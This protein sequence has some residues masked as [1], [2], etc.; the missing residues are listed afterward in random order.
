MFFI[1]RK[2]AVFCIIKEEFNLIDWTMTVL[3]HDQFS[4]V[5]WHKIRFVLVIV[6]DT[7]EEHDEVGVLLDGAGFT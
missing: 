4:D 1:N 6:V 3:S 2:E 7:M 5:G